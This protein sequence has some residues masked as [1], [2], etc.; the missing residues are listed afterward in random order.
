[1][2]D[3]KEISSKYTVLLVRI[4]LCSIFVNI[5]FVVREYYGGED[6][7]LQL[8]WSR[9]AA[10]E[11]ESVAAISCSGHGR[12]YLDGTILDGE[13]PV[14][15]CNP[16]YG[17]LDCSHF[18]PDCPADADSG[19]PYFLE[20][21]W[22]QNA[23]SSAVLV[24]GWHRMGYRY[25]NNNQSLMSKE[26]EN[27][28]R[29][30]HGMVGNAVT[31]GKYILFGAGSTQLLNAAVHALSLHHNASSPPTPVLA[32]I[33]FYTLYKQQTDVFG[34]SNFK[35]EGDASLWMNN[36]DSNNTNLIEFVTSPNNPDGKLNKAV[37]QGPNAK[38]IYDRVYYWPHFT[39][40]PASAD[41]DI[42]LFSISK[43]TGHA[44]AR[45]GWA[46]IKDETI[47]QRMTMYIGVNTMGVPREAQLR[48]LK[49][50]NVVLQGRGREIFEFGYKTLSNRWENLSQ[51]LSVS[52]RFSLQKIGDQY[53]RFF[54]KVRKPSPAYAWLR[55]EREEDKDCYAVLKAANI[56][57]RRGGVFGAED[58]YVRLS[59]LRSQDDF[60]LLL[61]RLNQLVLEED[62]IKTMPIM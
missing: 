9:K 41:E 52:T 35:F 16:C 10:A 28:I 59:L 5:L 15:E 45:F 62:K 38:A 19:D 53:C 27:Q 39:A 44:G 20:P 24:A 47:Y 29:K 56:I 21:F 23:E 26:L 61:H 54:H 40:I 48:A 14:C 8:S 42:M 30:L 49:L 51:T 57:G 50:I 4:C 58:R 7:E 17:G 33:P 60:D 12:T 3:K 1:M 2:A 55:C 22:M 25:I 13:K 6:Y 36:S 32:S 46:V 37:L 31:S 18:L 43:L 34:S 11:A